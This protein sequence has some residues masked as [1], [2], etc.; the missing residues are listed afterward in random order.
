M[1]TEFVCTSVTSNN[2]NDITGQPRAARRASRSRQ[3]IQAGNRHIKYLNFDDHGYS[4]LDITPERL[5]MDYFV[6]SDRAD[7]DATG[8]PDGALGDRGQQPAGP[9][10]RPK[11]IDG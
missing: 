8:E 5:Q 1:G 11:G 9:P 10:G 3:A 6:I 4:V 2:L 7:R